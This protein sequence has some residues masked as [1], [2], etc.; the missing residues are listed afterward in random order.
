MRPFV[1]IGAGGH[2]REAWDIV[3]ALGWEGRAL[4]FVDDGLPVG[5]QVDADCPPVLGGTEMFE[6]LDAEYVIAIGDPAARRRIDAIVTNYGRTA[7]TL[8]HPDTSVGSRCVVGSGAIIAPGAR[9][10]TGVIIG[11]HT[12]LNV[13]A[14]VSHDSRLG[15]YVMVGPN[16]HV[17]GNVTVGNGVWLG[18][19][20]CINQ[21][22]TIGDG[23]V[24]GS[25]AV[26]TRDLPA[27]VTAVGVPAR[28]VHATGHRNSQ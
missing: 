9:I 7:R 22:L 23:T 6:R 26:A 16:V 8:V 5:H 4:G 28:P 2:G 27:H 11:R 13:N 24:V 19:G 3:R 10:T 12:H 1:I 17:S 18:L 25:G 20:C 15:D 21:G 14:G